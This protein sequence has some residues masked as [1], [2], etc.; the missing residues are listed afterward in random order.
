[1]GVI[2]AECALSFLTSCEATSAMNVHARRGHRVREWWYAPAYDPLL[3]LRRR[4]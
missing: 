4:L 3:N 2:H 1:M